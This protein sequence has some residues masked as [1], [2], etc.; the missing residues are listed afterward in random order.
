MRHYVL[1]LFVSLVSVLNGQHVVMLPTGFAPVDVSVIEAANQT[2][3]A[4]SASSGFDIKMAFLT[5][6]PGADGRYEEYKRL[7]PNYLEFLRTPA[8]SAYSTDAPD[9]AAEHDRLLRKG[10]QLL[11]VA[12][13]RSLT[14]IYT[15]VITLSATGVL[16]D[17]K[18]TVYYGSG[19]SDCDKRRFEQI[20]DFTGKP[21]DFCVKSAAAENNAYVAWYSARLAEAT[22]DDYVITGSIRFEGKVYCEGAEVFYSVHEDDI[23]EHFARKT[24]QIEMLVNSNMS[25][26]NASWSSNLGENTFTP[27]SG[28]ETELSFSKESFVQFNDISVSWENGTNSISILP[29]NFQVYTETDK[30]FQKEDNLKQITFR[31]FNNHVSF[32]DRDDITVR[33]E[34]ASAFT[35]FPSI[36]LTN[37]AQ[38]NNDI[39]WTPQKQ[40]P[41]IETLPLL[42]IIDANA[43]GITSKTRN[44]DI[45]IQCI[46][47][48]DSLIVSIPSTKNTKSQE[49]T[50]PPTMRKASQGQTLFVVSDQKS[51]N[52]DFKRDISAVVRWVENK[53]PTA[54]QYLGNDTPSILDDDEPLWYS[55]PNGSRKQFFELARTDFFEDITHSEIFPSK[56]L[57]LLNPQISSF[58]FTQMYNQPSNAFSVDVTAY[59]KKLAV[60]VEAFRENRFK[61]LNITPNPILQ[62]LLDESIKIKKWIDDKF[63]SQKIKP[64][65]TPSVT[66]DVWNEEDL[67][68][69]FYFHKQKITASLKIGIKLGEK[70]K[71]DD[72]VAAA[73]SYLP[74]ILPNGVRLHKKIGKLFEAG[75]GIR[76][77][78]DITG[79]G[80]LTGKKY[81]YQTSLNDFV[82]DPVSFSGGGKLTGF[83]GIWLSANA[84]WENFSV[85]SASGA[86]ECGFEASL[87]LYN[88]WN[89]SLGER[90][91]YIKW[92]LKPF[93]CDLT[94]SVTLG[95]SYPLLNFS[96][97]EILG[98]DGNLIGPF[99][100]TWFKD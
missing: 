57:A 63:K 20:E 16:H 24:P 36:S 99:D 75:V 43:N 45:N 9:A 33:L 30:L 60:T 47:E 44:I 98:N 27:S 6:L 13:N 97:A 59:E 62:D 42:A 77:G 52:E 54:S 4:A 39:K 31:V 51:D 40:E 28:V 76:G 5:S 29:V 19:F 68:S 91:F 32:P 96:L 53:R 93:Q 61:M 8:R 48:M 84:G 22:G 7:D 15:T 83:L 37:P 81:N 78:I 70:K 41:C 73:G 18:K 67:N 46:F 89:S 17:Q 66:K 64:V 100:G 82:W 79:S 56:W 21:T 23:I 26:S 49:I 55:S 95:G 72:V 80:F 71:P 87:T 65:F 12:E 90:D 50:S 3:Q 88:E 1:L 14:I 38:S 85:L 58:S 94:A 74:I 25:V 92:V 10:V 2:L 35:G 69:R 34:G 86:G 11:N